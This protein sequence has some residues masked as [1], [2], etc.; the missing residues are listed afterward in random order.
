ME[1]LNCSK[2]NDM[3]GNNPKVAV[4]TLNYNQNSYT[5]NCI[6]SL[7]QSDYPNYQIVLIDNGSD[8][9]N[10]IELKEKISYDERMMLHRLSANI[11]YVGG[12]NQGI[13]VAM[14]SDPDYFLIMNNDTII[15]STAISQLVETAERYNRNAIV[16]GKVY[17][18]DEKNTLQ[19]IGQAID[20]KGGLDQRSI[21]KNRREED[22]GQYDNE[23]EMG[24]LD[25]IFWLLPLNI[26]NH[27]GGYSDYFYLYGEQN[28]YGYRAIKSGY[29]LIYSPKAKL[30]HKGG[31]TTCNGDK[32]SPKI[33]YWR[34]LATLK[35]SALHLSHKER[36]LFYIKWISRKTVKHLFEVMTGKSGISIIK[37]HV[38]AV[39]NFT[40]WN[41]VRYKDNGYNPFK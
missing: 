11:G 9:G 34:T 27:I 13:E 1:P 36:K 25:D 28:D 24:M 20:K 8:V 29:K 6:E 39:Y 21:V 33:E 40:H 12:I 23:M 17:N 30:W 14:N 16:S 3:S 38:L 10:Y 31:I 7:L 37:A 32:K 22:I 5:I 4:I 41:T 18:Y 26:Y 2:G 35:L 19:Y 15:D